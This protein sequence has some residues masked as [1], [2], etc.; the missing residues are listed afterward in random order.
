MLSVSRTALALLIA[1][2][3]GAQAHAQADGKGPYGLQDAE[4]TITY[5]DGTSGPATV[6]LRSDHPIEGDQIALTLSDGRQDHEVRLRRSRGDVFTGRADLPPSTDLRSLR[7]GTGDDIGRDA[8]LMPQVSEARGGGFAGT[9]E[10]EGW[11]I[12]IRIGGRGGSVGHED[13]KTTIEIWW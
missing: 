10:A 5:A 7:L 13:G 6:E 9:R 8:F 1:G 11:K 4:I 2:L 3:V 12:T